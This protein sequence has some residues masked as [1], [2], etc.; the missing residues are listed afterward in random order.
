MARP[1]NQVLW[2]QWHQRLTRQPASGLSIAEFCRREKVSP[3]SFYVWKRKLRDTASA[4]NASGQPAATQGTPKKRTVV[5]LPQSLAQASA[6]SE[7]VGRPSEF[8]QL[9][10]A[11]VRPSPWIELT[12]ADGTVVRLPQQN[13]VALVTVLRVLRGERADLPGREGL[14]A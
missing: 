12:L 10:V 9:P 2:S 14:H 1:V 7:G 3:H 6:G 4:R 5:R 13:L 11:A 8:L